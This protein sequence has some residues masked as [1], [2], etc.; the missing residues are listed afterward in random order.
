MYRRL[1]VDFDLCL[2]TNEK[3]QITLDLCMDKTIE[4]KAIIDFQ[5]NA[6]QECRDQGRLKDQKI[7]NTEKALKTL[8]THYKRKLF[9]RGLG[10]YAVG[11]V[12][13]LLVG[14]FVFGSG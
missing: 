13:G 12:A 5:E 8:D 7:R 6:Y 14:F 4:Q 3:N 10:K 9:R 1:A 11:I 2:E